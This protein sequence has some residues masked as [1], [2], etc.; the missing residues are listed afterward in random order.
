MARVIGASVDHPELVRAYTTRNLRPRLDALTSLAQRAIDDGRFP[1]GT[2]AAVIQDVLA[3]SIGFV[4]L[5][6]EQD[7]TAEHIASR[8]WNLLRQLGYREP[9]A[10]GI[11]RT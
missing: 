5:G 8:L 3:S 4:L 2:T 7:M 10:D 9:D 11:P 6:S 1:P